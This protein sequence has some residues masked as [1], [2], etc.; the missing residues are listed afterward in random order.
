M[1]SNINIKK[2]VIPG[3]IFILLL[4]AMYS[5]VVIPP[6][7]C[8]IKR[9]LGSVY[10]EPLPS[11]FHFKAS[12]LDTVE[13]MDLRVQRLDAQMSASTKDLQEVTATI[14]VNFRVIPEKAV[15]LYQTVG[16][17]YSQIILMPN[18]AEIYKAE[19]AKYTAEDLIVRRS[20]VSTG[21][22]N[23]LKSRL[24]SYGIQ[25]ESVSIAEFNFSLEFNRAIEAKVTAEQKA[26]QAEKELEQTK[27]EAQKEEERAK[28]VAAAVLAK[29][30][31]EAEAMKLKTDVL[32]EKLLLLEAVNKWDGRLPQ[33][34][35]GEGIIPLLPQ[36]NTSSP[37]SLPQN[38]QA[39]VPLSAG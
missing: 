35:M 15:Q 37:K 7:F 21:V 24:D 26:L 20:E 3:V 14:I 12:F 31:A 29:A 27:F 39:Q 13:I 23:S 33:Y 9:F 22:L 6:G 5:W 18:A 19:S 4:V 36:K 8:G 38:H 17:N 30:Q 10:T 2:I 28:G 32:D 16:M 25:V 1:Q 34:I 11:G